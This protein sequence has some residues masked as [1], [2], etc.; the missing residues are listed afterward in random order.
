[1]PPSRPKLTFCNTTN[2]GNHFTIG[3][4][5]YA[6]RVF[7]YYLWSNTWT[8]D[9]VGQRRYLTS[10]L[11]SLFSKCDT[12]ARSIHN[13]GN[14]QACWSV[15]FDTY[16]PWNIA[17][18][19]PSNYDQNIEVA[20]LLAAIAAVQAAISFHEGEGTVTRVVICTRSRGLHDLV[21]YRV[22]R[23]AYRGWYPG[24]VGQRFNSEILIV[25]LQ[26]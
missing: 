16:A 20:E 19:V 17:T 24:F 13:P 14:E 2:R 5:T 23:L 25:D 10:D 4:L 1:M 22:W 15:L 11:H 6:R 12:T 18:Y 21:C 7:N 9:Q 8:V 26:N 3:C